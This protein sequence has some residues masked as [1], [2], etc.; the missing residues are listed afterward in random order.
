MIFLHK[1]SYYLFHNEVGEVCIF[2][3]TLAWIRFQ[4]FLEVDFKG[5][6]F[7]SICYKPLISH[8]LQNLI[9]SRLRYLTVVE[10]LIALVSYD[11]FS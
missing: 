5:C 6:I 7:L 8:V 9:S 3:I 2:W 10:I 4:S 11:I 1:V